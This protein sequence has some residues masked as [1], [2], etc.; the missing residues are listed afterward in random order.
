VIGVFSCCN[1]KI[2]GACR[3]EMVTRG[4]NYVIR[5]LELIAPPCNLW[6]GGEGLKVDGIRIASDVFKHTYVESRI[7]TSKYWVPGIL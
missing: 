6:E 7:E 2:L 4:T 5:A 3:R 1:E